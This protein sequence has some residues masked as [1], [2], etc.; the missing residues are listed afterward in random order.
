MW[1][2]IFWIGLAGVAALG[3]FFVMAFP[4]YWRQVMVVEAPMD[5]ADAIVVLG[6][7]PD[8]RPREAARLFQAGVAPAVVVTGVGDAKANA[9]TL[10][11]AGVPADKIFIEKTAR[12]TVENADFTR[13][14]LQE[15]GA[16]RV[17][18]VTSSFHTRRALATFR[19]RIPG[20]EF[21]VVGTRIAWWDAPR[22]KSQEVYYAAIEVGKTIIYWARYGIWGF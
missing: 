8:A 19:K 12:S 3:L 17:L 21:G 13:P 15:L 10:R 14:I 2:K 9:R 7:E 16:R 18:L 20:I 6:G 22:G 4:S 1:V 11:M 5:R